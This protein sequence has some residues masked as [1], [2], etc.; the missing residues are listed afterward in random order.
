MLSTNMEVFWLRALLNL[1][2]VLVYLSGIF[3]PLLYILLTENFRIFFGK[4]YGQH[5]NQFSGAIQYAPGGTGG[6]GGGGGGGGCEKTRDR[7]KSATVTTK[8]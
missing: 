8:M 3:N 4:I 6:T 5:N 7:D 1:N 2:I